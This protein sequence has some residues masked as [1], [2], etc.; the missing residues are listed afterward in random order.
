VLG[1]CLPANSKSR[2]NRESLRALLALG[3]NR[4]VHHNMQAAQ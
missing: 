2:F 1:G 3:A 4:L